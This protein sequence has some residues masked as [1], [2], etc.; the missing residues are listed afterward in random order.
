MKQA[1]GLN[2]QPIKPIE[3]IKPMEPAIRAFYLNL[4]TLNLWTRWLTPA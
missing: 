4:W 3:L 1:A 2:N